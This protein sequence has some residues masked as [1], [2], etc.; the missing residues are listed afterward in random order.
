VLN[1]KNGR[2]LA[3]EGVIRAFPTC[4]RR[5]FYLL[6]KTA[7]FRRFKYKSIQVQRATAQLKTGIFRDYGVAE[8]PPGFQ[9]DCMYLFSLFL[10]ILFAHLENSNTQ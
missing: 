10:F 5:A 7:E 2:L 6:L 4:A 3:G 1:P 9:A 8:A